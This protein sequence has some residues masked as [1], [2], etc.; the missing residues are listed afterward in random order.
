M[1]VQRR[2]DRAPNGLYIKNQAEVTSVKVHQQV[3]IRQ[4]AGAGWQCKLCR[5]YCSADRNTAY[6]ER[7]GQAVWRLSGERWHCDHASI[8]CARASWRRSCCR[9]ASGWQLRLCGRQVA[10]VAAPSGQSHAGAPSLERSSVSCGQRRSCRGRAGARDCAYAS[11]RGVRWTSCRGS[12]RAGAS[13]RACTRC[14]IRAGARVCALAL[15]VYALCSNGREPRGAAESLMAATAPPWGI[16][17]QAVV[18]KA[19]GQVTG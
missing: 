19:S 11:A 13:A 2:T 18:Q 1:G 14:A 15:H 10:S 16:A 7:Q 17:L 6:A 5:E 8:A 3:Q 9:H 12:A 4:L